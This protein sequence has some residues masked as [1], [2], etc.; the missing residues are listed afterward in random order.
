LTALHVFFQVLETFTQARH[1]RFKLLLV[2][3]PL[4]VAIDE[5]CDSS[6]K[7][8]HLGIETFQLIGILLGLQTLAIFLF[9][10]LWLFQQMANCLPDGLIRL[11]HAQFFVPTPPFATEARQAH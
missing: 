8:A 1:S 3:Q 6:V 4:G 2:N 7:L 10:S 5:A 11:I 9:E